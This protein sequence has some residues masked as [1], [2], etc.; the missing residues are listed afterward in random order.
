MD[1]LN[2]N[3]FTI[4]EKGRINLWR[5]TLMEV[6]IL[7]ST[8]KRAEYAS[9]NN[10]NDYIKNAYYDTV[11]N[12][13]SGKPTEI[14]LIKKENPFLQP[15]PD[16]LELFL[17]PNYYR[18]LTII[19]F[20][21]IYDGSAGGRNVSKN[22]SPVLRETRQIIEKRFQVTEPDCNST[23]KELRHN[24]KNIRNK[25]LAH[26]EGESFNV[27]FGS[28]HTSCFLHSKGLEGIDF[29]LLHQ[30][31]KFFLSQLSEIH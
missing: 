25:M 10:I 26:A 14:N 7:L 1:E 17:L 20:Q 11:S 18:M 13:Q 12:K 5:W 3:T 4:E 30:F 23:I 2:Q 21:Q 8:I 27:E 9:V 29:K 16:Q 22:N 31:V 19:L 6:D 15:F 28:S 24:I